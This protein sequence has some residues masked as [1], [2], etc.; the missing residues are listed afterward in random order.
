MKI[1]IPMAGIGK[2]FG[3]LTHRRPKALL[4]LADRRLLDHVLKT[5]QGL[6]KA[7]ALQ[8]IFIIGYLGEQIREHMKETYPD[9]DITYYVQEEL[10]G[11]SHA[12]H[13][14]KDAISGPILLTYCDTINKTDFSFLPLEAA[15]G[16]ASVQEVE[17][18]ERFGVAIVGSNNLVTKLVEKP[19]TMEHR[20]A[21]TGLYYFSEGKALVK[22]I[23]TQIRRG[24]SVH[25]EYYLADAINILIADGMRIRTQK[26]SQWL[27][28]GTPEA[29]IEANAGLIRHYP[30]QKNGMTVEQ[31]NVFIHP[32]YIHESSRVENSIIGPNV[33]IGKNCS[34]YGSIV[35]STIV[36]DDSTVTEVTLVD[37]LIGKGCS[38][39]GNPMCSIAGDY[40][41][42]R[43]NNL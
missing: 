30:E 7:N 6:E 39:S 16:I 10:M 2:R 43:F 33:A 25:N 1:I 26:V 15:D 11:Q 9:K 27:D 19:K 28:A 17:D 41:V 22:A 32:V 35:K 13:L 3:E 4:R 42:I 8:Y 20:S 31:S 34:V 21:L 38:V 12:V 29:L 24:T 40:S 37:S 14:A 36:D 5:F 18:P 23:E